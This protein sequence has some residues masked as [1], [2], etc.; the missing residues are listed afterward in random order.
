VST[1]RKEVTPA[2]VT[3]D[4]LQH[5]LEQV[6]P[7]SQQQ[8]FPKFLEKTNKFFKILPVKILILSM[9][10]IIKSFDWI[11]SQYH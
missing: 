2:N 11:V 9:K 7:K 5:L 1:R 8:K 4:M 10:T 3:T 6:R